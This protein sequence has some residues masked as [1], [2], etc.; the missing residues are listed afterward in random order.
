MANKGLPELLTQSGHLYQS[1]FISFCVD[2]PISQNPPAHEWVHRRPPIFR[3]MPQVG[4]CLKP[5]DIAI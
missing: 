3:K 5:D 2:R 1:H 4:K